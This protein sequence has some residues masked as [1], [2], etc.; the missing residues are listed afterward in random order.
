L[1]LKNSIEKLFYWCIFSGMMGENEKNKQQL[2]KQIE[3]LMP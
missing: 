2:I 1:D 3:Y